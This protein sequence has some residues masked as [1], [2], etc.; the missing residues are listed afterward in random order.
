MYCFIVGE[1]E[2]KSRVEKQC[3]AEV[4][5]MNFKDVIAR[6]CALAVVMVTA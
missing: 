4:C 1:R 2:V 5:S 6:V 3:V